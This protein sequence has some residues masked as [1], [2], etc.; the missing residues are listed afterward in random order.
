MFALVKNKQILE[1]GELQ[2][3]FPNVI[4]PTP[5]Y[6]ASQGALE[7]VEGHRESEKFYWVTFDK[8]EVGDNEVTRLYISTPKALEDALNYKEDETPLM[9]QV[10]D[11]TAANGAGAMVDTDIQSITTGLKTQYINEYKDTA[12]KLLSKTDWNIIRQVERGVEIPS[13]VVEERQAILAECT[14][15][16]ADVTSAQDMNSFI[17][18]VNSANWS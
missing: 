15:L 7:I 2:T 17:D 5:L 10:W 11:Q 8:Y 9:T 6:A 3:L 16:I 1:I 4:N 14:R 12:N 18:V 13:K